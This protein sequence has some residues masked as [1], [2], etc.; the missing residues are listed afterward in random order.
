[1]GEEGSA[2][3]D[4]QGENRGESDEEVEFRRTEEKEINK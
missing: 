1:M 3:M 2:E 4:R